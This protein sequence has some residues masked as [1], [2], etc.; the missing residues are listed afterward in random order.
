MKYIELL[1]LYFWL[2]ELAVLNATVE[3][4]I[5]RPLTTPYSE[6]LVDTTLLVLSDNGLDPDI[7]ANDGVYSGYFVDF[8]SSGR[9]MVK[10]TRN[11]S[12]IFFRKFRKNLWASGFQNLEICNLRK[13]FIESELCHRSNRSLEV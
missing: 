8:T 11:V 10:V 5:T 12:F 6:Q 4:L 9:Y 1:L 2:G 7:T 3:A 13:L